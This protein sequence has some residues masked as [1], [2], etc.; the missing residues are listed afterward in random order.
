VFSVV[1]A[2]DDHQGALAVKRLIDNEVR[3]TFG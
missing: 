2:A 3:M 1:G